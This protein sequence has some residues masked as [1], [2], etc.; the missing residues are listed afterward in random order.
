MRALLVGVGK[1]GRAIEAVLVERSHEVASRSGG[2]SGLDP[3]AAAPAGEVDVAFEF[4][5]PDAAAALVEAL[6]RAG[7]RTVSGTTGWNVE[8]ARTLSRASGTPFLH[9]PNFSIGVA[10]LRLAA[11]EVARFL[12]PFPAFE[13]GLVERHHGAKKDAPSGTARLLA[14]AVDVARREAGL[15]SPPTPVVSLRHGG[16][17]GEHVLVFEGAN[18]SVELVHRARSRALFAE[19]A[20][21]AAEWL[22][23]S[24]WKGPASFA[25]F[26]EGSRP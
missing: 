22:V 13:P 16:Q 20:V 17:P 10:A 2:R 26:L 11:R 23:A 24:G 8:N 12:A 9:A 14:E 15:A 18:E 4:T 21:R 7:V 5:A 6:L 25:D 1:M 19:G 3:F